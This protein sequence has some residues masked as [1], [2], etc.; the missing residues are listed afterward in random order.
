[1]TEWWRRLQGRGR[2]YRSW[3]TPYR[4]L[5]TSIQLQRYTGKLSKHT[6]NQGKGNPAV[7]IR[8][9]VSNSYDNTNISQCDWKR[10]IKAF[11]R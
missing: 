7:G 11:I 6:S 1:M 5:Q 3:G 2:F 10:E 4:T 8:V 9:D